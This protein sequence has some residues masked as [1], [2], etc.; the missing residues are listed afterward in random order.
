MMTWKLCGGSALV[1]VTL[2]AATVGAQKPVEHTVTV[3]VN[4]RCALAASPGRLSANAGD[5]IV[6]SISGNI[7][8]NCGVA[9]GTQPA[10][11]DFMQ[12]GKAVGSP[13]TP[14]NGRYRVNA[15]RRGLYKYSVKLGS[16]VLDPELEIGS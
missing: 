3:T 14:G 5:T 10:M 7:P 11:D 13:V 12:N 16:I 6:L 1:I 15:G 4:A 2:G 9:N 8:S